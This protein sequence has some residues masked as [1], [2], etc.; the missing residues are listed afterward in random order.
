M[1]L[2][3]SVIVLALALSPSLALAQEKI[4]AGRTIAKLEARPT[5]VTLKHA[6]DYAQ[7]LLS[8]TLDNGDVVDVTRMAKLAL[9]AVV[10]ATPA[11]LVRPVADGGGAITVTV[12]DKTISVPVAVSGQ[13]SRYEV[14][15]VRD[16]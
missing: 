13:K 3:R 5:A 12:A 9:P 2:P 10:K 1:R 15:F 4:P 11:G 8:A 6:F 14:S 16:V 7:L